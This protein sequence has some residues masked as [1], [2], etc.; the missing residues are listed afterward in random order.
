MYQR[1]FCLHLTSFC[2]LFLNDI[3]FLLFLY[4]LKFLLLLHCEIKSIFMLGFKLIIILALLHCKDSRIHYWPKNEIFYNTCFWTL[5]VPIKYCIQVYFH[6]WNF[7]PLPLRFPVLNLH[8]HTCFLREIILDIGISPVL[9]LTAETRAEG[10]KIKRG[11]Y[12]PV[13]SISGK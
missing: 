9:N 7:C 3:F 5:L 1:Y 2:F 12:F 6:Y 11:I 8:R 4:S 13:Y 10:V